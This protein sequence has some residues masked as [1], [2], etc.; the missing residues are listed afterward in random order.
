M[1]VWGGLCLSWGR[2]S[3]GQ[4]KACIARAGGFNYDP[5]FHGASSSSS[6][7]SAAEPEE[8]KEKALAEKGFFVN[9]SR[10]LL[11]SGDRTFRLAKSALLS[12]R[13]FGLGWAVVDPETP[14][15]KGVKFCVCVKELLPWVMMPLQI[16]YVV[17]EACSSGP[18]RR[19]SFA[20]GSGTL[21]GHLLAGEERFSI[22]QDENDQVWYEI[23]SFSKPAHILS[24]ISYPYVRLRQKYFA[25]QST[26]AVLKHV[27]DQHSES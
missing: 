14:V 12:W 18:A 16:A 5:K 25:H 1:A 27:A 6:S 7:S 17:D 21:R 20:F 10:A 2:P 19:A 24:G 23:F 26:Q 11:G 3:R 13:H 4:Q 9:R 8:A 22:E 15:A